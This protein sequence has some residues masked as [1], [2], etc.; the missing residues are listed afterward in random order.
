[1]TQPSQCCGC[2]ACQMICPARCITMQPDP[3]GFLYP[4]IDSERCLRCHRCQAVCPIQNP[5]VSGEKTQTWVGYARSDAIRS[6]S[7]SGGIFTLA[8]KAVLNRG[9]VVFGAAFDGSFGV[10]HIC[11]ESVADLG[12][13]RGSKYVQSD[14][15]D[16]FVQAKGYLQNGRW[17]LF[18]GTA[19]QIA[20][21]KRYLGKACE[22]LLTIDVLCHGVPS[23]RIWK[24]YL[25]DQ[26]RRNHAKTTSVH[27]RDKRLGWKMFSM[28]ILFENGR[29]YAV[30]FSQDPF[31]E[32][33]LSNIDLRPSCH[34]CRFKAFPRASDMTIGDCWGIERQIPEMDDDRG[35]S[36]ILV[37]TP[38]GQ[39]LL[40]TI[41]P[42]MALKK[43]ELDSVLPPWADS[44]RPVDA[45][46][47]RKRFWLGV[48]RGEGF[49]ILR[50]YTRRNLLQRCIAVLRHL[51]MRAGLLE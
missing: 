15:E 18:T 44:R 2:T 48:A 47:N 5:P 51:G 50:E 28:K 6:Q 45:H 23:P 38:R 36:V 43:A 30:P 46:P 20:G 37:H 8:A 31:M 35:T 16:T 11:V 25:E 39:A 40:Q 22:Q 24:L 4:E 26:E 42:A 41:L 14:L 9:G 49:D 13:L 12:K 27:F 19:C 10:H 34:D 21:L 17:V 29:E 32:M 1:M 3:E 33:F 7:S